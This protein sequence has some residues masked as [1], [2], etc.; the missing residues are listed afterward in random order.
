[1]SSGCKA[2]CKEFCLNRKRKIGSYKNLRVAHIK[3]MG[4]NN[5]KKIINEV[6]E[7]AISANECTGALQNI[8]VDPEEVARFHAEYVGEKRSKV[9]K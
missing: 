6:F 5:S 2:F 8:S 4:K 7:G 9:N 3:S 1:M